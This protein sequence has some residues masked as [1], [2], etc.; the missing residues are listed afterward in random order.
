MVLVL[1]DFLE[2]AALHRP[3][4]CDAQIFL[5]VSFAKKKNHFGHSDLFA[6][7]V[8]VSKHKHADLEIK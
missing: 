3:K 6:F 1:T 4:R 8:A 5:N 2:L 7:I